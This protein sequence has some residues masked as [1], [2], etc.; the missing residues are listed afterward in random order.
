[1]EIIEN[2]AAKPPWYHR[3]SPEPAGPPPI[4][5]QTSPCKEDCHEELSVRRQVGNDHQHTH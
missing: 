5:G 2:S 4:I 3:D 1:L